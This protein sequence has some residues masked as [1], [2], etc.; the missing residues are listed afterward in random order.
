MC[1]I[2][3]E[4]IGN[5]TVVECE[6]SIVRSDAAFRLRDAVMSQADSE[7]VV[8]DLSELYALEGGALGILVFL[9][10]WARDHDVQLKMFNPSCSVRDILEIAST[11]SEFEI[12]TLHEMMAL[13][14]QAECSNSIAA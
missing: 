14:A 10:R 4:K 11:I 2:H 1:N 8:L 9:Q 12:A 13:L 7:I 5:M 3:I 6:G